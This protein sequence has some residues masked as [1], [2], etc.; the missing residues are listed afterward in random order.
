[1]TTSN[2]SYPAGLSR[3]D[4]LTRLLGMASN[5]TRHRGWL[6]AAIL[7][8][9]VISMVH[10][11]AHA[12]AHVP[13]SRAG[14][15]FVFVV[16]LA[17]PLV[18]LALTWPAERL[19]NWLIALTM[20]GVAGVRPGQSLCPGLRGSRGT[21]AARVAGV[22]RHDRGPARSDR[23]PR[24]RSG[25]RCAS[26]K[27]IVMKVFIA[28]GS[29][30]IGVPLVRALVAAGH[31][32]TALTRSPNKQQQLCALG[33]S[34]AVAD[35]LDRDAAHRRGRRRAALTR[36]ASA[37]RAAE[38]RPA[39]GERPRRDEL[40]AH[41]GHAQSAGSGDQRW[42]P[43]RSR[44]LVCAS[45]QIEEAP[46]RRPTL[47]LSQP[48]NRWSNR[49]LMRRSEARSR[50]SSSATA[51][52]TA[53]TRRPSSRS[54]KLVRKR[55]QPVVR[56]DQG[57]LPPI[58]LDD[59]VNATVLALDRA[60]AGGVYD[61]VDDHAVSMAEF[62]EAIATVHWIGRADQGARVAAAARSRRTWRA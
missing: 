4:P 6:I 3:F 27:D 22:V 53:T 30:T 57:Q 50:A 54:S 8:H 44:R 42:C 39:Q 10:G 21:R 5:G 25:D 11:A 23:T 16:I 43:S 17:G 26:S 38:G 7:V 58:H 29:G 51:C 9:L 47:W 20:A 56:G 46:R 40:P 62:V 2:P 61:I 14:S 35:A 34:A 24:I 13:L 60:P 49:S 15:L 18:G 36:R 33:A 45:A 59:A 28:G 1:M 52:S 41:R 19:G 55:R 31:Q 48:R 12:Q 37:D 32:V